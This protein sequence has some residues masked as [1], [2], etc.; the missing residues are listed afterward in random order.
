MDVPKALQQGEGRMARIT[1]FYPHTD[2]RRVNANDPVSE[3]KPRF[4]AAIKAKGKTLFRG[5][6]DMLTG[7]MEGDV[8][9]L[10]FCIT[11]LPGTWRQI[12][13]ET[14]GILCQS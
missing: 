11:E 13:K 10:L 1:L 7:F 14:I 3:V 2:V 4:Y 12:G 8:G 5:C 9:P 6:L